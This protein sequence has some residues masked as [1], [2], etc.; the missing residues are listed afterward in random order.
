[1]TPTFKLGEKIKMEF[2]DGHYIIILCNGKH[3]GTSFR[4]QVIYQ[5]TGNMYQTGEYSKAW[6]K[7]ELPI[8]VFTEPITL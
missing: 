3:N 2:A 5:H 1:M 4:G 6:I 8:S 7:N